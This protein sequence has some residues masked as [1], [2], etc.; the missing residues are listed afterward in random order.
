M[1]AV[2]VDGSNLY[3]TLRSHGLEGVHLDRLARWLEPEVGLKR[4]YTAPFRGHGP[5]LKALEAMGWGVR[6]ARLGREREKGVDVSI[7]V[8]LVL[9]PA[10]GV[11]TLTLVSG[12][13]DLVPAIE[14]A[15]A[16]GAKV[17]V[18][19]FQDALGLELVRHADEVIL[20]DGAPWEH[21]RW[22]RKAG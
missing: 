2:L 7:A 8:D 6:L 14:A 20:L 1:K 18:A 19:Q 21:L 15:K 13:T 12:D 9:L 4:F 16:L 22:E 3:Y 11:E 10:M 5:F 17:R